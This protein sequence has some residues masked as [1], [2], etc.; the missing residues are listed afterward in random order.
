MTRENLHRLSQ[1]RVQRQAEIAL[2]D[3]TA[4]TRH[5]SGYKVKNEP[6]EAW[7]LRAFTGSKTDDDLILRTRRF[8][9]LL[10]GGHMLPDFSENLAVVHDSFGRCTTDWGG[11]SLTK[12]LGIVAYT[13]IADSAD[14]GYSGRP[15]YSSWRYMVHIL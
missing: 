14:Y 12:D 9:F 11:L 6:L 5:F 7:I 2:V 8:I 1:P 15:F 13:C 4:G 10:I 3:S